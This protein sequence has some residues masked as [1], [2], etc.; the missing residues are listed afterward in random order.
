MLQGEKLIPFWRLK[1]GAGLN[2][3][4]L[5]EDPIP[6]DFAEWFHGIALL[7]YAEEG[8]RVSRDSWLSFERLLEGDAILFALF[9]N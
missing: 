6:F 3:K 8:E 1:S 7:P 9:L 2:L 4:K 5:L